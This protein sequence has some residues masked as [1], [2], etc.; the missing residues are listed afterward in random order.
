MDTAHRRYLQIESS[1]SAVANGFFSLLAT[2]LAF[3]GRTAIDLWGPGGL[4][5]DYLPQSFMVALMSTLIPGFLTRRRL[6]N[7]KVL[8]LAWSFRLPGNFVWRSLVLA[9]ASAAVFGGLA[10]GITVVLWRGPLGIGSVFALKILY[11]VVISIPVTLVGLR[12][13][14]ASPVAVPVSAA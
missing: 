14:L 12:A 8:P 2:W 11:G 6:L 13:S 3:G 10:M 4:A 9:I 7:G 1:V 5:F